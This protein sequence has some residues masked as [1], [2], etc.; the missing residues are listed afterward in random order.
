MVR[1]EGLIGWAIVAA[2]IAAM[3]VL[4]VLFWQPAPPK[5]VVMSTGPVD[6]AYHAYAQRYR[7]ILARS[8][9]ELVLRPST[10][11]VENLQRLLTRQDGV[12]IAL[13]QGGIAPAEPDAGIGSLGG[14]FYEA[15]WVFCRCSPEGDALAGLSGMRIAVGAEGS[16]TQRVARMLLAEVAADGAAPQQVAVGGLAAAR[17]LQAGELQAAIFVAA[18]EAPAVQQLLRAPGI[19]LLD[20][21]RAEAYE[22]RFPMVT[23]LKLPAGAVDLAKNLPPADVHLLVLTASL[24]AV[25]DLHPVIVDLLL[26]AAREVHGGG[27]V[28]WRPGTFPTTQ[29]AELPLDI[30]AERFYKTGPSL[31][32]R[33]L[34]LWA[35]VWIQRLLFIGLPIVAIGIP[36]LRVLPMLYRWSMRRRIY[37]WYGE[38]SFIERALD[39][40]QGDAEAQRR[41]LDEIGRRIGSLRVPPAFASEAYML[42]MHLQMVRGRLAPGPAPSAG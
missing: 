15:V 34:P 23:R 13:L 6:G 7:A 5:R 41:R 26:G 4:V 11:A 29:A 9:V 16:G 25:S 28:L 24:G 33:Y 31:L 1:R 30:D 39:A 14:M 3:A 22:R 37:R 35:A 10:G 40:G 32:Q 27:S 21:K 38:L 19:R 36:L 20:F 42:K 8:G 18:P 12:A 2:A 17:A